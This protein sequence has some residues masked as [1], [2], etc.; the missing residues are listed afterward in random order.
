MTYSIKFFEDD[1]GRQPCRDWIMGLMSSKRAAAVAAIEVVLAEHG[2]GICGMGEYGKNLGDG[3]FELRIRHDETVIRSKAAGRP[4]SNPSSAKGN[5]V[6]LRIFCYAYGD[7]VVLLL[8]GY[9]KGV[10][11]SSKKQDNE[12]DKAR[13]HLRAFRLQEQRKRASEKRRGV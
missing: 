8:G 2:M 10:A 1:D 6:L 5:D 7:K 12:I 11:P 4:V 3:L 9:D 13:R